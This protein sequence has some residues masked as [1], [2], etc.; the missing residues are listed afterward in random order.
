MTAQH[1]SM[2]QTSDGSNNRNYNLDIT[3]TAVIFFNNRAYF[4]KFLFKKKFI[5]PMLKFEL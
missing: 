2:I 3:T 5:L 4:K 1:R